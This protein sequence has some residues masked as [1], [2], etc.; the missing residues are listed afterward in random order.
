MTDR[1]CRGNLIAWGIVLTLGLILAVW[2]VMLYANL[3]NGL[4]N[5]DEAGEILG[6]VIIFIVLMPLSIAGNIIAFPLEVLSLVFSLKVATRADKETQK[7]YKVCGW[8]WT[9]LSIAAIALILVY[10]FQIFSGNLE[11]AKESAESS[12]E[13]VAALALFF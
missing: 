1:K 4:K 2:C 8:I 3:F 12:S 10:F 5:A 13:T 6:Q 7:G 11:S 9:G